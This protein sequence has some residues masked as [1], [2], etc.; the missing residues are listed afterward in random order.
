MIYR[1]IATAR[2]GRPRR[3]SASTA[4]RTWSSP[5]TAGWC[6]CSTATPRPTAIPT[7]EPVRGIGNYIRNSVKVTVDAY[8]RH[9]DLLRGR[10]RGSDRPDLRRGVPGAAAA[11]RRDARRPAGA[12]SATPRTSSRSRRGSTRPTTWRIPRSSTTRRTSGRSRGGRRRA[13]TARWSPTSRSCGCPGEAKEEF[14][15][16]T[17]F[18]PSRRDNMIAWLAARSDPPELR[19]PHRLQL[20]QAEARLRAA[21][22]RRADRPGPGHLPAARAVEP[23]G[24]ARCIRGSLLAIPHRPVADLRAAALPGRRRAGARCPSC[25]A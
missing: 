13:A 12:T 20:P 21:A 8:R 23:A 14:I 18:N 6:G 17:L 19:P 2:A 16:L 9:G 4:I 25:A 5:T 11:A 7:R 1:D 24:L 10:R 15:L 3:S 22:D